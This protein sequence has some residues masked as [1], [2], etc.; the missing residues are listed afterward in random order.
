[1]SPFAYRRVT[2]QNLG[3]FRQAQPDNKLRDAGSSPARQTK[4]MEAQ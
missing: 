1:M 4:F 2:S 3:R